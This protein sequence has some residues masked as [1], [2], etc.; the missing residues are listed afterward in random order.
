MNSNDFDIK[1]NFEKIGL[2]LKYQADKK[3]WKNI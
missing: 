2:W 3:I 1:F